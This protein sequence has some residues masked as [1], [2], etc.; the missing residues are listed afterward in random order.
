MKLAG[1]TAVVTGGS[2]GIG[3]AIARRCVAEGAAVVVTSRER[4]RAEAACAGL[5]APDRTLALACDVRRRADLEVLLA[6]TLQRFGRVDIW[7]NNAGRGLL[8]SVVSMDM[9]VCRSLFDTNL[10]GAID[11]MQVVIPQMKRQGDGVV[12]NI[13]SVAGHI[14][15]PGMAAYC[16]SK[17]A[18]MAIGRAARVELLGT[19]VHVMTVCPGYIATDFAI[20]AIKGE[21]AK[22]MGAAARRGISAERV[23][24][25]VLRGCLARRREV[26]VPWRDRLIIRL[27]QTLPRLVEWSMARMLRPADQVIA[28]A[29][30]ARKGRG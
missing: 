23:A 13:A 7:V 20:N 30:A 11:A 12:I 29:E 16:A 22:R 10:F 21:E 15:V 2:M 25:A 18:L 17:L 1:K 26:V 24:G 3:E 9:A 5:G 6:A 28:A 27:Y 14:A 19:G 8:D 4:Q